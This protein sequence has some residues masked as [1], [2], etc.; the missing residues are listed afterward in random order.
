[1]VRRFVHFEW[2]VLLR[3]KIVC[4]LTLNSVREIR[5]SVWIIIFKQ[6][7][8]GEKSP[9]QAEDICLHQGCQLRG[10]F[11]LTKQIFWFFWKTL[12]AYFRPISGLLKCWKD[13]FKFVLAAL[14]SPYRCFAMQSTPK[15]TKRH[16]LNF[17]TKNEFFK[18]YTHH[19]WS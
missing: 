3:W 5:H 17:N 13:F 12:R 1:M 7:S 15:C 2:K 6:F 14:F 9:G 10:F 19:G 4:T 11:C 8:Y 16:F 18:L